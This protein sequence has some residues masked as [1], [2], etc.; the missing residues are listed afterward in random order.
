MLGHL[1]ESSSRRARLRF[2]TF[3]S[4]VAHALIVSGA[5]AAARPVPKPRKVERLIPLRPPPAPAPKRCAECGSRSRSNQGDV[6]PLEFV[7]PDVSMTE[8]TIAVGDVSAAGKTEI[9]IGLEEWNARGSGGEPADTAFAL[10][11][12]FVDRQ[13]V[14]LPTNP[15]PDYPAPLRAARIEGSVSARFVVDTTGRVVME[16]VVVDATAHRLFTDA[17]I[18]VLRRSRFQPAE[19]RG[20]KVRQLV[21]QPFVFVLRE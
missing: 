7:R 11:S 18:D 16:S 19:L 4:V 10:R 13:V 20:R 8:V 3:V 15:S 1:V 9:Q 5:I 14:P 12:E 21:V 6:S 2:G 17:V